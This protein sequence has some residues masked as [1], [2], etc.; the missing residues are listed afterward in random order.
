MY[1]IFSKSKYWFSDLICKIT[2]EP[3]SHVSIYNPDTEMVLHSSF[4]G[5]E[6]LPIDKFAKLQEIMI[7]YPLDTISPEQVEKKFDK[8]KRSWYDIGGLL[9]LGLCFSIRR[10]LKIPLPKQNLW[11][12]TGMFLCTEWVTEVL[13]GKERSMI[14]PYGL[15][16]ELIL[17]GAKAGNLYERH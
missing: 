11:Q 4:K 6:Q 1:L 3:V 17:N 14:T 10:Y 2:E 7:F 12:S 15:Y 13:E 8:Y 5:V 9:F 16:Q